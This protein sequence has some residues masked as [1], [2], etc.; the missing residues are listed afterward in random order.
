MDMTNTNKDQKSS[1]VTKDAATL[2]SEKQNIIHRKAL[3]SRAIDKLIHSEEFTV[4]YIAASVDDKKFV[5][6]IIDELDYERLVLWRNRKRVKDKEYCDMTLAELKN[7]GRYFGVINYSR[8]NKLQLI[9][10][11]SEYDKEKT[12]SRR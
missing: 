3:S 6:K 12:G 9:Q 7:L 11:L 2:W 10:E 8:K 1:P 4:Y 5:L